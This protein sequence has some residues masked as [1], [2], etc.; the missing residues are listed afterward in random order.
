[1][2]AAAVEDKQLWT[3]VLNAQAE[4]RSLMDEPAARSDRSSSEERSEVEK[5]IAFAALS[6]ALAQYR[7]GRRASRA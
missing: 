7:W 6:V 1:M 3:A 2:D 5:R 4:M